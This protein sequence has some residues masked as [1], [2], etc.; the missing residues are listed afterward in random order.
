MAKVLIVY[1]TTEGQ[2]AKIAQFVGEAARHAGHEAR[3]V[4]AGDDEAAQA[5]EGRWDGVIV[6]ASIHEGRHQRSVRQW[7]HAQRALLDRVPSAFFQ[8]SLTS[9]VRDDDHERRRWSASST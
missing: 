9:I 3:V 8:V 2:T 1:G 4:H 5:A 6:G 7:I